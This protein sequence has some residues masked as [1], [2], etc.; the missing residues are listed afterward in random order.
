MSFFQN[1]L[2]LHPQFRLPLKKRPPLT[3]VL[4]FIGCGEVTDKQRSEAGVDVLKE[5]RM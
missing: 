4:A 3:Q 1:L 2:E 5:Y